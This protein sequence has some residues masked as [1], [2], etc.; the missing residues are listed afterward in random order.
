MKELI[1]NGA[2]VNANADGRYKPLHLAAAY[3]NNFFNHQ[4]YI[5]QFSSMK[6]LLYDSHLSFG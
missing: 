1:E 5:V 4:K 6:N 3:G 2:D